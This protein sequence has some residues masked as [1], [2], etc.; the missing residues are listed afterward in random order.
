MA[1]SGSR[2]S[3]GDGIRHG[4]RMRISRS[5]ATTRP[6]RSGTV[7]AIAMKWRV[8]RKPFRGAFA[9]VTGG[10]PSLAA[11]ECYLP[12]PRTRFMRNVQPLL[13]AIRKASLPGLWSEGVRLARE[14]KVV[15]ADETA[16]A[17]SFRV[18]A[19]GR[20]V[21]PTVTLYAGDGE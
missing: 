20:A 12:G 7:S 3:S 8:G 2:S 15:A 17:S 18:R 5:D 14:G 11:K 10:V 6:D 21:A 13:D 19:P 1:A 9:G 4:P 16:E